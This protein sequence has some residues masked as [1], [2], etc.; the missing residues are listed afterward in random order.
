M[1]ERKKQNWVYPSSINQISHTNKK[2]S[3][4]IRRRLPMKRT[5]VPGIRILRRSDET[6]VCEMVEVKYAVVKN[7]EK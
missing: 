4:C 1:R 5:K 2:G 7:S 6:C 3:A